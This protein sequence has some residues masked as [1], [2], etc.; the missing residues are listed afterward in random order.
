MRYLLYGTLVY[1]WLFGT[2]SLINGVGWA[3]SSVFR[4]NNPEAPI[5]IVVGAAICLFGTLFALPLAHRLQATINRPTLL[6]SYTLS[7]VALVAI[8]F[9]I[10]LL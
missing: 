3:V 8:A 1:A 10:P 6:L 4:E 5:G 2:V 7:P 9:A